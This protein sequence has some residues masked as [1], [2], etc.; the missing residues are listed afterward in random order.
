MPKVD[1]RQTFLNRDGSAMVDDKKQPVTLRKLIESILDFPPQHLA[2]VTG[3]QSSNPKADAEDRAEIVALLANDEPHFEAKQVEDILLCI[4]ATQPLSLY[5]QAKQ[6]F[7]GAIPKSGGANSEE[8]NTGSSESA[9]G[10]ETA[11]S[12]SA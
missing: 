4:A 7:A 3:K 10:I 5:V 2:Q 8:K 6:F 11:D 1:V 12:V 9:P